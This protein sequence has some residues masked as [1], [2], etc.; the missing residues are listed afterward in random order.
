[1]KQCI[2]EKINNLY[3]MYIVALPD[4]NDEYIKVSLLPILCINGTFYYSDNTAE[5]LDDYKTLLS[6]LTPEWAEKY[7]P[8]YKRGMK[9]T[10]VNAFSSYYGGDKKR[11]EKANEKLRDKLQTLTRHKFYNGKW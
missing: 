2:G 10:A 7:I 6:A 1:M 4:N 8:G 3:K 5:V 9:L 11:E